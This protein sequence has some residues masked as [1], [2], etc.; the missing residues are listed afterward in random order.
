MAAHRSASVRHFRSLTS[1]GL[2][3]GPPFFASSS[4]R[5]WLR[6]S[7]LDCAKIS[8]SLAS[9]IIVI[10]VSDPAGQSFGATR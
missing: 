3:I 1:Q 10:A 5:P 4:P 8:S 9:G 7:S 6:I 2:G